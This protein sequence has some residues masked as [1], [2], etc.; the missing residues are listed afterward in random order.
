LRFN[1][2]VLLLEQKH[3][4]VTLQGAT[5]KWC[6]V[7]W[8]DKSGCVFGGF[9]SDRESGLPLDGL[10]ESFDYDLSKGYGPDTLELKGKR[11][12]LRRNMCQGFDYPEGFVIRSGNIVYFTSSAE[13]FSWTFQI[14]SAEALKSIEVMPYPVCGPLVG[15]VFHL[16]K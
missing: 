5:G 6:R 9:L 13:N 3:E 4:T 2:E 11:F 12:K 14:L 15:H 7:Q 8:L 1:S 10:Y 16:K